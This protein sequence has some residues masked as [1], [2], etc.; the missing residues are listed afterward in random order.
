VSTAYPRRP[1]LIRDSV[2]NIE[3]SPGEDHD[4]HY[5]IPVD[6]PRLYK[7]VT[8][9]TDTAD[10]VTVLTHAGG[11]AGVWR[12]VPYDDRG[13]DLTDAAETLYVSGEQWRHCPAGTLT[14][15]R[16]KT[17]GTTQARAGHWVLIS[18]GQQAYA[19]TV[20]NGGAAGGT[21][22]V[23]TGPGHVLCFFDGTNWLV[24]ATGGE[25]L[26]GA[27]IA[28]QTAWYINSSTGSDSAAG[29]STAPL[30]TLGGFFN[31]I[32]NVT[33]T[34]S[35]ISVYL[36]DAADTFKNENLAPYVKLGDQA[37]LS[38]IGARTSILTGTLTSVQN[39]VEA[40]GT[41]S[42]ITASGLPTSWTSSLG[43]NLRCLV[44]V[45]IG[46]GNFAT[47]WIMADQGSKTALVT[48][49]IDSVSYGST[50]LTTGAFTCYTLTNFGANVTFNIEAGAS[51]GILFYDCALGDGGIHTVEFY[52]SGVHTLYTSSTVGL[53]VYGTRV[54][55]VGCKHTDGFRAQQ[56]GLL[57]G[58][59]GV[60]YSTSTSP[61]AHVGSEVTLSN[62][63]SYG[64]QYLADHGGTV[65]VESGYWAAVFAPNVAASGNG[66]DVLANG[67]LRIMGR[68]FGTCNAAGSGV[69]V[70]VTGKVIYNTA[71]AINITGGAQDCLIG[72]TA[73]AY[74]ALPFFNTSNGA[75]VVGSTFPR[76]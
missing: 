46:G 43:A 73:K 22:A 65:Q 2:A 10:Q 25:V 30:K 36:T 23:L 14:A 53:D 48:D 69:Y 59:S 15:A 4:N 12:D 52:G 7:W 44:K 3:A 41:M 76:G 32:R 45:D 27:D 1:A 26:T 40:S 55:T 5:V 68:L 56:G 60:C 39:V 38:F 67:T 42:T 50:S 34:A 62:M 64:M 63:V 71:K 8:N 11:T 20:A 18:T 9:G 72:G 29:T 28:T 16:T 17:L 13:T 47:C 66:V 37:V 70:D 75:C 24:R 61:Q 19:L 6:K 35:A 54:S 33:L 57:Q 58:Y 21:L 31:R 49:P 74:G 51:S